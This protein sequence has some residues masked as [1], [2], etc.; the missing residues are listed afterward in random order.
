MR[1]PRRRRRAGTRHPLGRH[2]NETVRVSPAVA[3]RRAL[4]GVTAVA[5]LGVLRLAV[6]FLHNELQWEY[7]AS[8]SRADAPWYY[9]LA[10]V[11]GGGEGSLLLFAAVVGAVACIA[12]RRVQ[13]PAALWT[14][15]FSVAGLVL[16]DLLA[17]SP[18][19]RLDVPAVR[20][21]GLT[22]ILEHPA[23]AIHP[24]LLYV[25]LGCTLAAAMVALDGGDPAAWL[26]ATVAVT[27]LAMT[28]GALWSYVEQGWGGYWAWDP[29]ENTSLL[30]WLAALVALHAGWRARGRVRLAS[31]PWVLTLAGAALVR[32]GTAPSVHGFAEHAAVGW[33]LLGGTVLTAALAW[34]LAPVDE[35]GARPW[36]P[37]AVVAMAAIA[38][39]VALG[40]AYPVLA[41]LLGNRRGAVRGEFFS[42]TVGPVALVALPFLIL[43]LRIPRARLAHV[44]MLVLLAGVAA[45]TFDRQA[46]VVVRDG[47]TVDA[48]GVAVTGHGVTVEPGPRFDVQQVVATLDVD[49]VRMRPALV[50]YPER[51]GV[52]AET[53]VDPGVWWDVQVALVDADDTGTA[54][55]KVHRRPLVWLLWLGAAVTAAGV[56][57]PAGFRRRRTPPTR[58]LPTTAA[59]V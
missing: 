57:A 14:A 21:F 42:R 12:A 40:T 55:V 47:A 10:G 52:L 7:V 53:A 34:R 39:V 50:A 11:W 43:R 30:V 58:S 3:A 35:A 38:I 26:R 2:L 17:A 23:M 5:W 29:V 1:D 8:H 31:V 13:R 48:A 45:S 32:S 18:F 15:T 51:G 56:L 24:P 22:P 25:G 19:H 4:W 28:I 37:V 33:A 41:D 6:A 9:R 59:G 36:Q 16:L 54:T 20:G 27:T 44:G 46:T 49:G